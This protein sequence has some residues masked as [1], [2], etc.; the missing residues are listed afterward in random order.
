LNVLDTFDKLVAP[1][2]FLWIKPD[3]TTWKELSGQFPKSTLSDE[4][5]YQRVVRV[6]LNVPLSP[7]TVHGKVHVTLIKKGARGRHS[8]DFD[9]SHICVDPWEL[10]SEPPMDARLEIK[11]LVG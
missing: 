1:G 2:T 6:R 8:L 4:E 9:F 5:Q 11:E 10:T 7:K 3:T